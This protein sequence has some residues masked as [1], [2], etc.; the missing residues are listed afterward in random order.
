[1]I[2]FYELYNG[3]K[4]F[5]C[6]IYQQYDGYIDGVGKQLKDFIK[7]GKLVNGIPGGREE[8]RY[9]NGI[10]CLIGQF[11]A[12]FKVGPGGL[13]VTNSEDDEEYNYEVI[14][15]NSEESKSITIN[16][17]E[18]TTYNEVVRF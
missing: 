1:M 5:V 10:G 17:K 9:F 18:D 3:K 4:E 16:C 2:K 8:V 6:S 11:V 15:N 12:K 14:V 7:S 13:Y